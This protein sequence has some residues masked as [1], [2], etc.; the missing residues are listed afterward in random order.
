M[1]DRKRMRAAVWILGIAGV[2][3]AGACTPLD[4]TPV[5][6]KEGTTT[7]VVMVRHCERD[8]GFDPPLN[9]EGLVRREALAGALG[10]QGVTAIYCPDFIRNVESVQPLADLLGLEIHTLTQLEMADS[11][12]FA[13]TFVDEI[14]PQHAGGTVLWCGN[15]GPV[16]ETQSGNMQELYARLGGTGAPPT[17]YEHLYVVV[18]PEAGAG[19]VR[20]IKAK[21]GGSS[22]LDP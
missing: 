11:K 18:I 10:E 19:E 16:T 20:F 13:N 3:A 8:E 21:Y 15:V 6:S 17:R 2:V 9:A 7:T 4:T 5:E 14:L 12:A 1:S 22:S